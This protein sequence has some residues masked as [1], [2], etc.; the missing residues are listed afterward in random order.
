MLEVAGIARS[1]YYYYMKKAK[2]PDKYLQIKEEIQA[3]FSENQGRYGYRRITMELK[4]RGYKIN[5]K[6]V[7][8]L[9]HML[10]LKCLVRLK[11]YRSY[12]GEVGKL[13]QILSRGIF[14]PVLQIKNGLQILPNFISSGR[15][16]IYLLF[17]ICI[18]EKLSV[19]V[20]VTDRFLNW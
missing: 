2:L 13:P 5:H 20:S 17:L 12:K 18:M 14:M 11:K 16:Y 3:I 19:T 15:N 1:T 7:Q 8:K 9:M 4:N 6:T 10:N